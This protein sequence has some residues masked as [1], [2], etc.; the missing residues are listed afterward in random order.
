M[1][2]PTDHRQTLQ[3][4]ILL[5]EHRRYAESAAILGEAIAK[6]PTVAA[7]FYH[8]AI[9][10]WEMQV[11]KS[12]VLKTLDNAIALN[13]EEPA[14]FT[15]RAS[16]LTALH[17]PAEAH[18]AAD[19][20]LRLDPAQAAAHVAKAEAYCAQNKWAE[21][22][23]QLLRALE[24]DADEEIA[25]NMLA[26]VQRMQN[27]LVD[28]DSSVKHLLSQNPEDPYAHCNAG[29]AALQKGDHRQANQHFREALRL[30]ASFELAREGLLESFKARSIFYRSYL[31]YC[32]FMQRFQGVSQWAIIIGVL[33]G[34]RVSKHLLEKVHPL[35][36]FAV[37][38]A[39]LIF[40]LWIWLASGIGNFLILGDNQARHALRKSERLEG[41]FVGGMGILAV[42]LI[43][44]GLAAKW[45]GFA[46]AGGFL[47]MSTLP[48]SLLFTNESP[49][50]RWI[51]GAAFGITML[52]G[53]AALVSSLVIAGQAMNWMGDMLL[54]N[55]V[56]TAACT[57]LGNLP[58]LR[59]RPE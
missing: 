44:T 47:F 43:V 14:Y 36:A 24:N 22:E 45:Y 17:R 34:V 3:R 6:D 57:W 54:P 31:R 27:K 13:P 2:D 15:L 8:L 49:T 11:K 16:L 28:A 41:I 37:V 38:G 21:A 25:G 35:A 48:A 1:S 59:R 58:M 52:T 39:Y 5:R 30:D 7:L 40:V 26:H 53:V 23:A 20:S 51:F 10:Q 55:V 12:E 33:I 4:A 32:F 42:A 46:F 29:W 50:G 56:V 19:E 18:A 9:T